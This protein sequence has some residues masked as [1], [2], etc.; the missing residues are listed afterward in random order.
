MSGEREDLIIILE[1]MVSL[2]KKLSNAEGVDIHKC[3][4]DALV[5]QFKCLDKN[6]FSNEAISMDSDNQ[7][8]EIIE[9]MTSIGNLNFSD[10][11][12][13][14]EEYGHLDYI[15]ISLNL[16]Q[17]RLDEKI[18][19]L[20]RVVKVWDCFNDVYII[21]NAQGLI[22][23]INKVGRE[24]LGI[25]SEDLIDTHIKSFFDSYAIRS[26]FA[27]DFTNTISCHNIMRYF[28]DNVDAQVILRIT[29]KSYGDKNELGYCYRVELMEK[30]LH[31]KGDNNPIYVQL[32]N[33]SFEETEEEKREYL[34]GMQQVLVSKPNLNYSE[35][36]MLG[37]INDL[38]NFSSLD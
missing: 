8:E 5:S 1:K 4:Y 13:V 30:F 35:I 7:L 34:V 12:T 9:R 36:K 37:A 19:D 38:L 22:K 31:T 21:V 15:A 18:E 14:K 27:I 32:D 3:D 11:V 25:K 28:I 33:M 16:M 20:L 26:K 23:D 10:E 6:I 17:E 2:N 29:A 24:K